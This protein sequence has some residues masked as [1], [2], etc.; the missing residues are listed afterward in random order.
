MITEKKYL[1]AKQ[2]VQEYETNHLNISDTISSD[3]S[4]NGLV[5]GKGKELWYPIYAPHI[6]I[7]TGKSILDEI[8]IKYPN[9]RH[10][11]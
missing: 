6:D 11:R 9:L 3:D 10:Y 7:K 8:Y 2:I 5:G 1:K 4:K